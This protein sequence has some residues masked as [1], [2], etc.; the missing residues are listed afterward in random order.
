M[1]IIYHDILVI[2][3][4]AQPYLKQLNNI[5][6]LDEIDLL[7]TSIFIVAFVV[8]NYTTFLMKR[9]SYSVNGL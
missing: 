1:L 4:D 5:Q 7:H 3:H 6:N 8:K 9:W 2:K